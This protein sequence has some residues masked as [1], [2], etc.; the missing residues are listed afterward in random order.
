VTNKFKQR[1]NGICFTLL[2]K[3]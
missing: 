1:L 2:W 3:Y